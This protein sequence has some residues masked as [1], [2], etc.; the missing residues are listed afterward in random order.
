MDLTNAVVAQEVLKA[1]P[2]VMGTIRTEMRSRR[3]AELSVMQFRALVYI[4]L[5]RGTSLSSL[6]E[7]LGLT[8]PTVSA[9][10]NTMVDEGMVS[11]VDCATDRRKVE[12]SLTPP[13]ENLLDKANRGT[14]ERLR[15]IF[16]EL[17]PSEL[18]A[19]YE[20]MLIFQKLFNPTAERQ[21]SLVR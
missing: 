17:T 2:G 1:I 6:S 19:V 3:G 10:I 4:N 15:E 14:E 18:G 9:M 12:L 13:G 7:H 11:R 21:L 5:N 8:L 16:S 20:V